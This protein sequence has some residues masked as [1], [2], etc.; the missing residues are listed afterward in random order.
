MLIRFAVPIPWSQVITKTVHEIGDDN[1][2]GLAAQLSFYFLLG[3]FPALLF[4]V[5]L[6]GYVPLETALSELLARWARL[7]LRSWSS[8][9]TGLSLPQLRA[10]GLERGSCLRE[11]RSRPR[12]LDA[13]EPSALRHLVA[14]LRQHLHHWTT[15]VWVDRDFARCPHRAGEPFP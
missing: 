6:V 15:H 13:D 1:C 2:L 8:L 7:H 5:A 4:L 14:V 10:R 12:R 11:L 9:Q 3:L